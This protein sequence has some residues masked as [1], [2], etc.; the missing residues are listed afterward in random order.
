MSFSK[1]NKKKRSAGAV[2]HQVIVLV[3]NYLLHLEQVPTSMSPFPQPSIEGASITDIRLYVTKGQIKQDLERFLISWLNNP[4]HILIGSTE[5]LARSVSSMKS[6]KLITTL[7]GTSVSS[8]DC[9]PRR[10]SG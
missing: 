6:W 10:C 4:G 8:L 7:G 3:S 2:T 1:G 5:L 9:L